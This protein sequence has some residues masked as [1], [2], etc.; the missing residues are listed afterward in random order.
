LTKHRFHLLHQEVAV[1]FHLPAGGVKRKQPLFHNQRTIM[2][3]AIILAFIL[4]LTCLSQGTFVVFQNNVLTPPP[5]RLVRD[6]NGNP[7]VGTNY[8]AQLTVGLSPD[9][10]QPTTAAPSRFRVE[11]TSQ[12][13][14]WSGNTINL[15]TPSGPGSVLMMQVRVWDSTLGTFEQACAIGQ[16]GVLPLFTWLVPSGTGPITEHYMHGFVGGTPLPCPE[17]GSFA[18]L[19]VALPLAAICYFK[20]RR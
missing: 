16:A 14:T 17:P 7:L 13:G 1:I 10:L 20:R 4:P 19:L 12:P 3:T 9:S 18:L 15:Q 6:V 11:T 8:V 2:R 5:D